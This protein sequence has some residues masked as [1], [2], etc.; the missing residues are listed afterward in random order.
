VTRSNNKEKEAM[1][2]IEHGGLPPSRRC[3][4]AN[5]CA[6]RACSTPSCVACGAACNCFA[7]QEG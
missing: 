7:W 1:T 4:G 5:E 2:R 6:D 3:H